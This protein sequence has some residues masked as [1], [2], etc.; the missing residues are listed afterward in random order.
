MTA[1]EP[2]PWSLPVPTNKITAPICTTHTSSDPPLDPFF[3]V[4]DPTRPASRVLPEI[5]ARL[6]NIQEQ[7]REIKQLQ[8]NPPQPTSCG[9]LADF[10]KEIKEEFSCYKND[11]LATE[12]CSRPPPADEWARSKA[13][14]NAIVHALKPPHQ[15]TRPNTRPTHPTLT[16]AT[17]MPVPFPSTSPDHAFDNLPLPASPHSNLCQQSKSAVTADT[18]QNTAT[19]LLPDQHPTVSAAMPVP[20]PLPCPYN[21]FDS[22]PLP[23]PPN[24]N[25]CKQGKSAVTVDA[26]LNPDTLLLPEQ[27]LPAYADM[28]VPSLPPTCPY[29]TFHNL[30]LPA[31]SRTFL[32]ARQHLLRL[33]KKFS[34]QY[35][36]HYQDDVLHLSS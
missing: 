25:L 14:V 2:P 12:P 35:M 17:E 23:A 24:S 16:A 4:P 1:V 9:I 32:H 10:M 22:R 18:S 19:L 7:L 33:R 13:I 20:F 31:P 29:N 36:H 34:G 26:S 3:N 27:H 8:E 15:R 28:H 11:S 21:T 6:A 5:E 30:L